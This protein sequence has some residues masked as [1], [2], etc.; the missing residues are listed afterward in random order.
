[1]LWPASLN[2][3]PLPDEPGSGRTPVEVNQRMLATSPYRMLALLLIGVALAPS[4][5]RSAPTGLSG[6]E[7]AEAI[8]KRN[9][10]QTVEQVTQMELIDSGGSKITREIRTFRKYY[11]A[12]RKTVVFFVAPKNIKGTAFLTFDYADGAKDDDQWLYLP[13]ARKVRRISASDRGGYFIG[14]DFTYEDIKNGTKV[15]LDDFTWQSGG[16]ETCGQIQCLLLEGTAVDEETARDLGYGRV[17]LWVD[18]ST[19]VAVRRVAWDTGGNLLKTVEVSD[20]RKVDGIW[21]PH[22]VDA[23]NHKSR[24][25]TIFRI[26]QVKNDAPIMD[27]LFNQDQLP[28]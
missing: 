13:A 24:H 27:D 6:R 2:P 28:R 8:N 1:M 18:P 5:S 16:E 15:S 25:R 10:G 20:I 11:G 4:S 22:L 17:K 7:I 26:T 9:D 12:D 19:W 3:A 21:T 14:T 23:E